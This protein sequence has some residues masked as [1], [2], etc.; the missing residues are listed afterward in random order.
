MTEFDRSCRWK[1]TPLS[2]LTL[3]WRTDWLTRI[4]FTVTTASSSEQ[5]SLEYDACVS[6]RPA[7][8]SKGTKLT[9]VLSCTNKVVCLFHLRCSSCSFI[10]NFL[11]NLLSSLQGEHGRSFILLKSLNDQS[12][13]FPFI[14]SQIVVVVEKQ[15]TDLNIYG[16]LHA[17]GW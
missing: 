15:R 17:N 13:Q 3:L 4:P 5:L 9:S 7:L 11:R 2:R 10:T 1:L 8:G 12:Y 16:S 14:R 6:V